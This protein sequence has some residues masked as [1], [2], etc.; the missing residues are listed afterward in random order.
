MARKI[1][2]EGLALVKQWEGLVLYTY[3]DFD[4]KRPPKRIMPGDHV[5]GTLTLG[6]GHTLTATPGR[7]I[8]E[9][10]AER[11]LKHDLAWA[12]A[13]VS[14]LVRVPLNDNQFAALVSFVFNVGEG[15]KKPGDGFATSTL[16]K[17]LNNGDYDAVP[18]EMLRWVH[19]KGKRMQGLVN[20]RAQEGALWG[21]GAFISS[22]HVDAAPAPAPID[23]ETVSW[24]AT[25]IS[26][27]AAAFAGNG[28]VQWAFAAL[29]VAFGGYALFRFIQKRWRPA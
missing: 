12:E 25:M 6:Y 22:N 29:I 8:S 21:K 5:R 14:R 24:A 13:A 18:G 11:L 10:E 20:R 23:R 28:P 7:E 15:G 2:D 26:S 3:D 19:S 17:K 27:L 4:A 1:N 9:A 16:L